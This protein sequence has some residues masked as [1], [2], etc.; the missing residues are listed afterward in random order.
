MNRVFKE[1][2]FKKKESADE[3]CLLTIIGNKID[4]CESED[5][6]VIKYKNG[7][8]IADVRPINSA[9]S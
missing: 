7:S 6:R 9:S 3:D 1:C 5:A 2:I 4:L 8:V